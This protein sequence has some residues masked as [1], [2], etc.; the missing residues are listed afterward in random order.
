MWLLS[1][2][3]FYCYDM[4]YDQKQLR[5]EKRFF[6]LFFVFVLLLFCFKCTKHILSLL[7]PKARNKGKYL[8]VEMEAES[9]YLLGFHDSLTILFYTNQEHLPIDGSTHNMLGH[10][11]SNINFF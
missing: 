6:H 3:G 9:T 2:V 5:E 11:T 10:A 4:H 7:K 1:Y 8:N